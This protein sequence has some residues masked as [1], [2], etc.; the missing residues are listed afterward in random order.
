MASLSAHLSQTRVE[1]ASI[2]KATTLSKILPQLDLVIY[3]RFPNSSTQLQFVR[4]CLAAM[5]KLFLSFLG[6]WWFLQWGHSSGLAKLD[7]SWK[8]YSNSFNSVLSSIFRKGVR[9][10]SISS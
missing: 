6:L 2:R 9:L 8:P 4:K 1:T 5:G 7:I 10:C 3:G